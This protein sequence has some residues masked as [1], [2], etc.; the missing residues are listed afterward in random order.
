MKNSK[1]TYLR[2]TCTNCGCTNKARNWF[3]EAEQHRFI[4]QCYNCDPKYPINKKKDE[5]NEQQ[6]V[7]LLSQAI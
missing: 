4:K 5:S 7:N 3:G 6:N 1:Y 2:V